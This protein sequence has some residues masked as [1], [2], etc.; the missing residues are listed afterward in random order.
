[1][2]TSVA[3]VEPVRTALLVMD[4]QRFIVERLPEQESGALVRR[5]ADAIATVRAA[6]GTVGYVRVGFT[7]EEMA[8]VPARNKVFT[9]YAAGGGLPADG[10]DSAVVGE[11]APR[12][13][14][15]VVR[16]TRVGAFSTTD[17]HER[18]SRRDVDTLV[19]AGVS[20]SGVVLSTVRDA[21][22]R[23]YRLLVLSDG[24]ADPS[25]RAHEVLMEDVFPRQ[26]DVV[27]VAELPYLL[28]AAK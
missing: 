5:V 27:G 16:K 13:G 14:D 23:D 25:A 2:T 10:P 12:E 7:P 15:I 28:G 24:C 21:S 11:L 19:L 22:D 9:G 26:A 1:M 4:F 8:A 6:G 20:T 18:L 3:A 17:L